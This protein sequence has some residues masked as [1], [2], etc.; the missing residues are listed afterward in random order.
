MADKLFG[1][2]GIRGIAG[3]FPL[4]VDFCLKLATVLAQKICT[5]KKCVAIARDTRISGTMLQSAL[6]AGF[7]AQGVNVLDLGI[8][9]T[10]LCT[11]LTPQLNVDMSIMI[12]ASHNP[13]QDNGLKL[14]TA[15]GDKFSDSQTDELERA[16]QSP[17]NQDNQE[18]IGTVTPVAAGLNNY[19]QTISAIAPANALKGL[20]IVLDAAN[21]AFSHILTPVFKHLGAEIISLS[22]QPNGYNINE[23]CGSQHTENLS[24]SV[25]E[26]CYD[27]GIAVDGDGDRIILSDENGNRMNGDQIIAFLATYLQKHQLLKGNGVVATIYSNLGLGK[28]IRSLGLEFYATPVG[29][30]H[31]IAKMQQS[32]C[33]LGGEE[34]GHMVLSDY[35]LTGDALIAAVIL[36]LAIKE[37]GRKVST[38]FPIFKPFPSSSH[39][40]RFADKNIIKKIMSATDVQEIIKKVQHNLEGHGT[41]LVRK[42]GTEPV[43]RLKVEDEDESLAQKCA[44]EIIDCINKISPD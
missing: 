24:K 35:S 28:Y 19:L 4:N 3:H 38:I 33:N 29:E 9:P 43:I 41:V 5:N 39:N 27:F 6:S 7:T 31:V 23:N 42:S 25:K 1:T 36:S 21:G 22:D 17:D 18:K 10:P 44:T 14:I 37:D 2:D 34:S 32:G 16:I 8:I 40:L 13:Y 20:K 15:T 30:R 11:T 26:N 12:T